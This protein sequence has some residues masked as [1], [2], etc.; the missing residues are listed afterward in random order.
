MLTERPYWPY[1]RIIC[2]RGGGLLAPENTLAALR[3]A[4]N[5]GFEGVEFDVKLSSDDVPV[6]FHDDTLERTTDGS[7]PVADVRF[8]A[9]TQFDAGSWFANEFSGEPVPAFAAASALCKEAGLWANI[10]IKP[11]PGREQVTGRI[12]ARM[13]KLLWRGAA[14]PPLLSSFSTEAL[15]AA[16]SEAPELP[17]ALLCTDIPDDWEQSMDRLQCAALH[18]A[19]DR[20]N[21]DAV[22]AIQATR[23]G[24]LAYTVNDSVE[25]I[26]LLDM[27]VDAL[28]TDQLD[29]IGPHFA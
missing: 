1:P 4:R 9:I 19:F 23:R 8:D 21:K 22:T 27:G 16:H 7:G 3:Y 14:L 5:L 18:C 11:C 12:V 13:A 29:V 25:A 6:L 24:V 2:H 10:E 26:D 20:L 17:R 15:S 28:I